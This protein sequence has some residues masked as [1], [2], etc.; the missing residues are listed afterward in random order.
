[1]YYFWS[2]CEWEI[3]L[4]DFPPSKKFQEKKVDVYEQVM[5]NWDIFINYVWNQYNFGVAK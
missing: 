2:K 1:M 4:S 5:L 3:I